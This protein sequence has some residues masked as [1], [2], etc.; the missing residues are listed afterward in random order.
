MA[1]CFEAQGAMALRLRTSGLRERRRKLVKLRDAL[2]LR[3]LEIHSVFHQDF[4]KPA[5]EV[6]LT[7]LLPVVDEIRYALRNLRR[8]MRP[9]RVAPSLTMLGTTARVTYQGKGRCLIIGTWNYPLATL[10]GPLVSAVAAG[11]TVILKPS[12]FTPAVNEVLVELIAE[13]FDPAEV[14]LIEG[15]AETAQALLEHAFD[16]IFFTGSPVVGKL[17]MAAAARNLA[18]VTLEL[19]GKSPVIVDASSDL[20]RA[21]ET[22]IWGKLIN[23]GQTCVA[24]DTLFV[25]RS[26]RDELLRHCREVIANR[27]GQS[28]AEVAASADLARMIDQ[29]HS[30]RVVALIDEARAEGAELLVGGNHDLSECYIAPTLLGNVPPTARIANEEIFGPVLPVIEFDEIG[31]VIECINARPKPLALYLWSRDREIQRR[32]LGETSSGG[33]V[34]NHC[35]VQ[36]AHSGLPFGGIGQSGMGNA[37]GYYGFKAFS[38]ERALL[39]GGWLHLV[40]AFFPPYGPGRRRLIKAVLMLLRRL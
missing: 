32:I 35:I 14:S 11:N 8:W 4:R 33:V 21:A 31:E 30:E 29:R 24:P 38:H 13:V 40:K 3:R 28:D 34:V 6:D 19:G 26:V 10:I 20:R 7:E 25:E 16:H 15:G 37:H 36:F 22:I 18:S 12:E 27:Y 9:R 1:N 17:V 39:R 23:A 2:L 5:A